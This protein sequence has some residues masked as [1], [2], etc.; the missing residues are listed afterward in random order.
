MKD[1]PLHTPSEIEL[2]IS[3]MQHNLH[4]IKK[5]VKKNVKISSVIKGNAYGHGIEIYVPAAEQCGIDHF[6]VFSVDEAIRAAK[7]KRQE[8]EL[9][10]M[11]WIPENEMPWVLQNNVQFWIFETGRLSYSLEMA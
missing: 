9:M 7:V 8:T 1:S 4:F 2:S 11:G 3:A 10:I 5:F 6:A